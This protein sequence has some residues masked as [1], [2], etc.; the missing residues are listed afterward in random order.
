MSNLNIK[1]FKGTPFE[2]GRIIGRIYRS[3]GVVFTI[4]N[5]N[6][7]VFKDQLKAYEKHYPQILEEIRGVADGGGY[8]ERHIMQKLLTYQCLAYE[9]SFKSPKSCTIFSIKNK[10]GVFVGR[11]YDWIPKTT[12]VFQFYRIQGPN[13]NDVLIGT[14]MDLTERG[15]NPKNLLYDP[16]DAINS[17]GLFIGLT[18]AS[19]DAVACGINPTHMIKLVAETCD[20]V[21]EAVSVFKRTPVCL[22]KNFFIADRYGNT[23]VVEHAAKKF[24][25]LYP[26]GDILIHTNH[27]QDPELAKNERVLKR[28]PTNTTYLRYYEV[29][30]NANEKKNTFQFKDVI[31]LLGNMDNYVYQDLPNMG[32]IWTLALDIKRRKYKLYW[33]HK[34]KRKEIVLTV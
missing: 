3:N 33:N 4:T 7:S 30:R 26:K 32:T 10:H 9:Q 11:N 29:L 28:Y 25:V 14:D 18:Y 23:A 31:G 12:E 15:T 2:R 27:Y 34:Q 1:T 6:T 16:D 8:N 19:Y 22:P 24:R 5:Q 21:D 20:T 17:K 13:I